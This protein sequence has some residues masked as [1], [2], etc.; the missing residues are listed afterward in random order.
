MRYYKEIFISQSVAGTQKIEREEIS[1]GLQRLCKKESLEELFVYHFDLRDFYTFFEQFCVPCISLKRIIFGSIELHE[2]ISLK[3][4]RR[5]FRT[6]YWRHLDKFQEQT[7]KKFIYKL[8]YYSKNNLDIII[9][10]SGCKISNMKELV[11]SQRTL[12]QGLKA[13][14]LYSV[15]VEDWEW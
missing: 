4:T 2:L 11:E 1:L 13:G 15:W 14:S 6:S 9:C 12:T 8:L 7:I 5:Q 3:S 10:I